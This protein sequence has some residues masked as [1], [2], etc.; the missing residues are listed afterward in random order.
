MR[1]IGLA[2]AALV[3]AAALGACGGSSSGGSGD[4]NT[5]PAST[6]SSGDFDKAAAQQQ[7]QAALLTVDDLPDGWTSTPSDDSDEDNQEVQGQLADCVGVDASIFADDG[8]DKAMAQ[9]D[10]FASPENGRTGSFTEEVDVESSD[11]VAKDFEVVNSDKLTGCLETVFGA[12][13]K[14]KFAEDPQTKD[15]QV[16]DVTAERGGIPTYGDESVGI[17]ITVP[18][19]I[20]GTDAKV[21]IDMVFV[22]VGNAVAE[23]SFQNTFQAFPTQAAAAITAKAAEKLSRAAA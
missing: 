2:L 16:G 11:R 15:A 22:R 12:F 10:E 14:Q 23:L 20:A 19:S 8:P 5:Q 7:A 4:A 6:A 21:I 13:L 18:F 3:S 17:E 1:Q 9:S